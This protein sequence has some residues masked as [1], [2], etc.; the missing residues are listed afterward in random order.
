MWIMACVAFAFLNWFMAR[1]EF[2]QRGGHFFVAPETEGRQSIL[3]VDAAYKTV[4]PVTTLTIF[5]LDRFM[6]K[7]LAKSFSVF[8]VA[9]YTCFTH[10]LRFRRGTGINGESDG[11][12][13]EGKHEPFQVKILGQHRPFSITGSSGLSRPSN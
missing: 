13:Q 12:C 4:G 5:F 7:A 6:N 11:P 3:E 9:V 1:L 8:R 10:L 2:C